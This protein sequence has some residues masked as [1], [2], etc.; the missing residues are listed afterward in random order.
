VRRPPPSPTSARRRRD[1]TPHEPPDDL[2]AIRADPLPR[3]RLLRLR[4]LVRALPADAR[5]A[6]WA[7][8]CAWA[9]DGD[10]GGRLA[11]IGIA[12]LLPPS[13]ARAAA[14][15]ASDAVRGVRDPAKRV[16]AWI[17]LH[18]VA[19]LSEAQE[20]DARRH[21]RRVPDERLRIM[22]GTQAGGPVP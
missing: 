10:D 15:A 4:N 17:A 6:H 22:I 16:L 3:R 18:E 21:L 2:A 19:P 8:A 20:S 14:A 5:E 9:V 11:L 1:A 12:R 13:A 7:E